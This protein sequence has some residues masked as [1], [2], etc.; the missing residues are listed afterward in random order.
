MNRI[1]LKRITTGTAVKYE[2]KKVVGSTKPY[3][4]ETLN[5]QYVRDL[6]DQT[7]MWIVTFI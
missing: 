5:T 7:G 2:V 3:V 6:C 4:G 1:T